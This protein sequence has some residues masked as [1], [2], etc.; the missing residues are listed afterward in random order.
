M[1]RQGVA[2]RCALAGGD[3]FREV[4]RGGDAYLLKGILH[5]WDD[6]PARAILQSVQRAMAPGGTLLLLEIDLP[7]DPAQLTLTHVVMDLTM[8][9]ME[10]GK[11]RTERELAALLAASGFELTQM[12]PTRS[13]LSIV[14]ATRA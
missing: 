2:E 13:L 5:D 7:E 12:V 6:E 1:T 11:E 4:P 8:L 9:V 3:F 10:G 14:E